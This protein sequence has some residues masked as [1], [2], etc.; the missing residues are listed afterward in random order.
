MADAA[1]TTTRDANE[2]EP[3]S[4]RV[5][6]EPGLIG[7]L[8]KDLAIVFAALSIWAAGDAWF[9]VTGLWLA[10]VVAVGDAVFVGL[11]L[12]AVFHEWGHYAGAV[13]SKS[14]APRV[15]PRGFALFRFN[16]DYAGNDARQFHWMTYGGHIF[17]WVIFLVLVIALPLDSLGRIALVSAIFGFIAFATFIEY[18]IVKDTWAG[19]A[20]A[21]RIK[22]ITPRDF[23]QATVIGSLAGLFALA[24]LS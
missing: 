23:Q 12:A 3:D 11:L 14:T 6:P 18:H 16:F 13:A 7:M 1:D 22:E 20:P 4:P 15:A 21:V 5:K 9:Q 2:A 24:G 17:H 8:F 10:Q 19:K